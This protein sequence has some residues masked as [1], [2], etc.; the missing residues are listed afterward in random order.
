MSKSIATKIFCCFYPKKET[1]H[2]T[3]IKTKSGKSLLRTKKHIK[4][5]CYK[6][7]FLI[8]TQFYIWLFNWIPS[9]FS[10]RY[11][12][13]EYS[14]RNWIHSKSNQ[15]KRI[16][17][18]GLNFGN[19]ILLLAVLR[20]WMLS[21]EWFYKRAFLRKYLMP[22]KELNLRRNIFLCRFKKP[23]YIYDIYWLYYI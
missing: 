22:A 16:Y 15:L 18:S 10:K 7:D 12:S 3:A 20:M 8:N 2:K 6:Q 4:D 5:L 13:K 1:K 11:F 21:K 19:T 9:H 17:F 23:V 14:I